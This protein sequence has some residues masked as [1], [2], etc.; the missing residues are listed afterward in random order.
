MNPFQVKTSAAFEAYLAA[1]GFTKTDKV[2]ETGTYWRSNQNG[3]HIQVP[4]GVDGFFPD[5]LIKTVLAQV[6]AI[7]HVPDVQS[8][9]RSG[10]ASPK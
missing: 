5:F 8:Q 3:Q 1:I 2:T 10:L 6:V 9:P 7:G 4:E